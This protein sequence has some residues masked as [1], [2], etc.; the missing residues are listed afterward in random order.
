MLCTTSGNIAVEERTRE[1]FEIRVEI[2]DLVK[3]DDAGTGLNVLRQLNKLKSDRHDILHRS[4]RDN[5]RIET[6]MSVRA[7]GIHQ[8]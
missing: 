4:L 3:P 5:L 8:V 7:F 2:A 6:G 1:R